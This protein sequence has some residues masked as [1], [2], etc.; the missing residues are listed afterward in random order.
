[1]TALIEQLLEGASYDRS[2]VIEVAGNLRDSQL[3]ADRVEGPEGAAAD[4]VARSP[5]EE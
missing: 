4:V 5:E 3:R 1:M 2:K